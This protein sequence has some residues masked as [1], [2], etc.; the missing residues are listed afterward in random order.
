MMLRRVKAFQSEVPLEELFDASEQMD[1]TSNYMNDNVKETN[2]KS[3]Q[4]SA[5]TRQKWTIEEEEEIKQIFHKC[6]VERKRPTRNQCQKAISISKRKG[7]LICLRKK[8]VFR[9][10]ECELNK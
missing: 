1:E 10:I 2:P 3:K 4:K 5:S 9:M 7:G 8:D 6:F